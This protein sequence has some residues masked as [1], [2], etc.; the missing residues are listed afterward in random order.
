MENE[1]GKALIFR[2]RMHNKFLQ[3]SKFNTLVATKS[4]Q[5]HSEKKCFPE[6]VPTVR[7]RSEIS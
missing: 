2:T 3:R 1:R 5:F 4:H 6:A 7:K